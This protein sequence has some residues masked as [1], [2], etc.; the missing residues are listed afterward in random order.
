MSSDLAAWL[1]AL[2]PEL[3]TRLE[4]HAFSRER[5]LAL[6][7]TLREGSPET[8]RDA[9]NRVP[10]DVRAPTAEELPAVP[11]SDTERLSKIGR[12]ALARGGVA[13]CVMAGGMATRMGGVVK[14][15]AV[16]FDGK[17]FLDLRLAENAAASVRAGRPVPLWLMTS[18]ATDEPIR[19]ALKNAPPHVA[20]FVQDLG[21]RLTPDGRLFQDANG[22]PS[23]YA[24]GHG[25][26]PDALIRSGLLDRFIESGGDVVWIANLDNLGATIDE[27][28]LGFFL[29]SKKDV[30]VEVCAKAEGDRGGIP[31]HALGK[32]QVLEEFRLPKGFDPKTVRVFNTNTFLVRARAL[33]NAQI[34]WTFFE[35]EKT[36]DGKPAV[37]FERLLQ[38]LTSAL[39]SAYV[40]VPR[41]G[42]ASRFEPVKDN[43]ELER[44]R[45][46]MRAI[47]K[48]RG[49]A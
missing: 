29:E 41:E 10:G 49:F 47:A 24:T 43:A 23:T 45:A 27:T 9:R 13:L 6:A 7:A 37:Q 1:E 18:D 11:T 17:T 15:L 5:L 20:T 8:R 31:V 30:M 22:R 42:T 19:V 2:D 25:D 39:P 33:R 35:V 36:V 28:I 44:R 12:D 4:A 38:E 46:Q 21:L 14:A 26:L 3:R 34:P 16:A 32:I 40:H 48:A